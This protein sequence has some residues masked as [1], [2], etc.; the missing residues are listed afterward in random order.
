MTRPRD[1]RAFRM[2][3]RGTPVPTGNFQ[4]DGPRLPQ[5][6]RLSRTVLP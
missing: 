3:W 1:G 5:N 2:E 6:L 4:H